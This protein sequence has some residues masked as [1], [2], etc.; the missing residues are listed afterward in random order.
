MY[1]LKLSDFFLIRVF[2][3]SDLLTYEKESI[4]ML[5][6]SYTFSVRYSFMPLFQF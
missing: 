5:I 4:D 6:S 1:I 3:L 2:L